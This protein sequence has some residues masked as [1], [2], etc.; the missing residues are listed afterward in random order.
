MNDFN[1]LIKFLIFRLIGKCLVLVY[2]I[3]NPDFYRVKEAILQDIWGDESDSF[4]LFPDY[5]TRFK[6]ADPTNFAAINE[7]HGVFEAVF[8]APGGLRNSGQF[9]RPFTAIDGTHTKSNYRMILL[10]ACGID[11]N[12][13]VIPLAWALVPIE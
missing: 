5:I 11:A 2:L 3:L 13:H 12:E 7:S 8:F 6:A 9:L 10:V 4:A 1:I